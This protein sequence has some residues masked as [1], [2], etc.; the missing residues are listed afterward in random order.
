MIFWFQEQTEKSTSDTFQHIYGD[1]YDYDAQALDS[2]TRDQAIEQS[3]MI[4]ELENDDEA[5]DEDKEFDEKEEGVDEEMMAEMVED[6]AKL[7][8]WFFTIF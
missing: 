2:A 6:K 4:P 3:D 7:T 8:Y 5:M 1:D